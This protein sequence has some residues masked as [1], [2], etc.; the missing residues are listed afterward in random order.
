M[1]TLPVLKSSNSSEVIAD[2][3]LSA[4]APHC[5]ANGSFTQRLRLELPGHLSRLAVSGLIN[6]QATSRSSRGVFRHG[7]WLLEIIAFYVQLWCLSAK[8]R[9]QLVLEP[10]YCGPSKNTDLKEVASIKWLYFV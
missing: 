2:V 7:L 3:C 4:N 10:S 6:V 5:A 1:T 9:F 8:L